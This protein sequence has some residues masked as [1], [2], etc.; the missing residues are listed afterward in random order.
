MAYTFFMGLLIA[1]FIAWLYVAFPRVLTPFWYAIGLVAVVFW[2]PLLMLGRLLG[3]G[4]R[5]RQQP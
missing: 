3:F 4:Q 5:H 2:T 1:L